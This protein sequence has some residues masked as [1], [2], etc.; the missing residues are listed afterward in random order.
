MKIKKIEWAVVSVVLLLVLLTAQTALAHTRVEIGPY[1]VVVGWLHEPPVVGERNALVFEFSEG[2]QPVIG[3]EANLSAEVLYA[4]RSFSTNLTPTETPGTY[5]AELFPTVR[6]Q[7]EV[8]LFGKIGE[9]DVDE[10]I[11]PEEVFPAARIQFPQAQPD[12]IELQE[13]ITA[14]QADLQSARI[15]A[16]VGIGLGLLGFVMALITLLRRR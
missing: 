1:V 11:E 14:L 15:L 10:T 12:P 7:Y 5:T 8:R 6:G 4:G 2:E 16:Y 3:V 9:V 13:E